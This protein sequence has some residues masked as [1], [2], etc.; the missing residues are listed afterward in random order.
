MITRFQLVNQKCSLN[1]LSSV[2]SKVMKYKGIEDHGLGSP[3]FYEKGKHDKA[4]APDE[5]STK[6]SFKIKPGVYDV[7]ISIGLCG[8]TQ[9]VW[10]ENFTLKPDM[11]YSVTTNLNG[12]VIS[13]AG[14][15]KN[16]KLMHMYPSGTAAKQT[17]TPAPDKN[18]EL[19]SYTEVSSAHAC[20]PG[21]YDV[22]LAEGNKYEWRKNFVVTTG[23]RT[24]V[25]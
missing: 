9:K 10:L 14:G 16:V 3:T 19:G 1:G 20:P 12:G 11:N 15:N 22:L 2:N 8:K 5:S 25:K 17:G 23:S 18:L 21:A 24:E 6:T 4:I 13:Y 7:L